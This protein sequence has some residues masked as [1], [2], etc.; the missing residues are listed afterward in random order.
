MSDRATGFREIDE[1]E[2][3]EPIND[4][5]KE[6]EELRARLKTV[7]ELVKQ[8]NITDRFIKKMGK[9]LKETE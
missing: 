1:M 2:M 4:L 6:N 7:Y 9:Y 5:K 8:N 3:E